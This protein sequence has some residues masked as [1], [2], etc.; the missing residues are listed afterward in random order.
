VPVIIP[1]IVV[2]AGFGVAWLM[3]R[4]SR[5]GRRLAS[6]LVAVVL[7]AYTAF[8]GTPMYFVAEGAGTNQALASFA[9]T[10]PANGRVIALDGVVEAAHYWMPLYLAYDRPITPLDVATDSGRDAAI[11][12]LESASATDPVTVVTAAAQFRMDAVVG[13]RTNRASWTTS[14]IAETTNPVPRV[15]ADES[16]TLDV[17]VATGLRTIGVPFGGSPQWIAKETG[18]HRP[19]LVDGRPLRWTDGHATLTVPIEGVAPSQLSVSLADTGPDG[20]PLRIVVNG[21]TI[22][23]ATLAAGPWSATLDLTGVDLQPGVKATV[24]LTG[25]AREG[26][27]VDQYDKLHTFGVQVDSITFLSG[28]A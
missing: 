17:I 14:R 11:A 3:Q 2:C 19:Q 10:V 23:D 21:V 24:E 6:A 13:E 5:P 15:V 18:F 16:S 1:A 28:T 27:P 22:F 7:V 4:L 9:R 20:G 26:E 8:V 12:I 25:A